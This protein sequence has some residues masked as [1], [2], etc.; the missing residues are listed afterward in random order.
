MATLYYIVILVLLMISILIYKDVLHPMVIISSLWFVLPL[1]YEVLCL[2]RNGYWELSSSFYFVVLLYFYLPFSITCFISNGNV[3]AKTIMKNRKK[4]E[5]SSFDV[6]YINNLVLCAIIF[7][8]LF[9]F[10]VL[11]W[12]GTFN[13]SRVINTYRLTQLYNPENFTKPVMLLGRLTLLSFPLIVCILTYSIHVKRVRLIILIALLT[14]ADIITASKSLLFKTLIAVFCVLVIKRELSFKRLFIF[15]VA[16]IA[17]IAYVTWNRDRMFVTNGQLSSYVFSYVFFSLP[18]FD[19]LI[20]GGV[21]YSANVFGSH[22]LGFF[23]RLFS[24]LFGLS[25]PQTSI[26]I[27][28]PIPNGSVNSNVFTSLGIYYLDYGYLGITVYGL[29]LAG[30]FTVLYKKAFFFGKRGY[31]IFYFLEVYTLFVSFF[32][33]VFF[34]YL[35]QPIQDLF[36]ILVVVAPLRIK[37]LRN[38]TCPKAYYDCN[39][40]GDILR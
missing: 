28:L 12:A 40:E 13:I 21:A 23:Y 1:A 15:I 17:V 11:R 31:L 22:T 24:K 10:S 2:F 30:L 6:N 25:I 4:L 38:Y 35:S 14:V 16:A 34:A 18:A 19:K 36:W 9:I 20:Q 3:K 37:V 39:T 27:S 33:D 26:S 29:L 7:D 32:G 5:S 8:S